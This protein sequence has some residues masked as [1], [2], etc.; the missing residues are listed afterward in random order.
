MK[1]NIVLT[2]KGFTKE[3]L[4]KFRS[5]W[6]KCKYN[7]DN[8]VIIQEDCEWVVIAIDSSFAEGQDVKWFDSYRE[9]KDYAESLVDNEW[10]DGVSIAKIVREVK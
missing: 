6:E 9:A 5:D 1:E 3:E 10:I 4:D 2:S 7:G 8:K